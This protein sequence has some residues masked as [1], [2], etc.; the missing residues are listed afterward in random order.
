ML[1]GDDGEAELAGHSNLAAAVKT[2]IVADLVM[3]L[4]NVIGVAAAAKGD[5]L[6]LVVGLVISIPL[7]IYGSTLILK[8]MDRFPIIIVGGAALL[9]WVAGEMAIGDPSISGWVAEH[10][11]LHTLAPIAGA[12]FVVGVGKWLETR[13]RPV[14]AL[15]QTAAH[16]SD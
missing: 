16:A 5:V 1:K 4:D 10:H 3:S 15:P 6:L 14:A 9:G 7:I 2:I 11:Y 12:L 13:S 8:M